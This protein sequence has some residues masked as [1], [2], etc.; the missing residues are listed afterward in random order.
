M[1][2]QKFRIFRPCPHHLGAFLQGPLASRSRP[3]QGRPGASQK[4]GVFLTGCSTIRSKDDKLLLNFKH[5]EA[6]EIYMCQSLHIVHFNIA[7]NIVMETFQWMVSQKF[8][9]WYILKF[10]LKVRYPAFSYTHTQY[11]SDYFCR[12]CYPPIVSCK[13]IPIPIW[14][15]RFSQPKNLHWRHVWITRG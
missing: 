9:H 15:D 8:L 2:C 11:R 3:A 4:N 13:I 10:Q 6:N 1:K 5:Y 7:A 12:P 14:L